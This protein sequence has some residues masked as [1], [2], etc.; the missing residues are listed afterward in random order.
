V[1]PQEKNTRRGNLVF[2]H[3]IEFSY[4]KQPTNSAMEAY[5][6]IHHMREFVNDQNQ[7]LPESLQNGVQTWQTPPTKNSKTSSLAS[8]RLLP[9]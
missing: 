2:T 3:K 1:L 5:Y 7:L 4:I 8:S 9:E 6:I